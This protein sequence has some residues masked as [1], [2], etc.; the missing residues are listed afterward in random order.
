MVG[1]PTNYTFS[2]RAF[3]PPDFGTSVFMIKHFL[4]FLDTILV[5]LPSQFENP[6]WPWPR[7]G[8][9]CKLRSNFNQKSS[10]CVHIAFSN[11]MNPH[12]DHYKAGYCG[13]GY[14]QSLGNIFNSN[15][16][17]RGSNIVS[18]GHLTSFNMPY[19]T[20]FMCHIG[21]PL[22][23]AQILHLY[24][25]ETYTGTRQDPPKKIGTELPCVSNL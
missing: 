7:P 5:L 8:N 15:L 18:K 6:E 16:G 10:N 24:L 9:R 4:T 2:E 17:G 19:L 20:L 3:F 13:K 12:L 25:L 1:P 22:N 11:L 21:K 14:H 23:K